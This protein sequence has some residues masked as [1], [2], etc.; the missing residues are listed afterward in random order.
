MTYNKPEVI[1]LE[2]AVNAIQGTL[3]GGTQY[4]D[5]VAPYPEN[6]STIMAYEGDE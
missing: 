2:C 3:K 6:A 4:L 5:A 1:K